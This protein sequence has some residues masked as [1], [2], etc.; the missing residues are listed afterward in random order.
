MLDARTCSNCGSPL[1][2]RAPEGLCPH[3]LLRAGL[4]RTGRVTRAL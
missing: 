4:G 1:P 2:A 3:C